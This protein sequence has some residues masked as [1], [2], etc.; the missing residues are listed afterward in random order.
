MGDDSRDRALLG[1]EVWKSSQEW[2]G[3]RSAVCSIAWLDRFEVRIISLLRIYTFQ[4]L[5]KVVE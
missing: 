2:N 4:R 1:V 5:K 3:P